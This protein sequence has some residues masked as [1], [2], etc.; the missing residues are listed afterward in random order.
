MKSTLISFLFILSCFFTLGQNT[1][2]HLKMDY[3][4]SWDG[5]SSLLKVD[6]FYSP[7][8]KDTTSF[9]YGWPEVGNQI[10]IFSV[11]KNIQT[12]KGDSVSIDSANRKIIV[13]HKTSGQK[14]LHY[15]INGALISAAKHNNANEQFRPQLVPGC[16]YS[17]SFN[18][19]MLVDTNVYKTL[20]YTWDKWP[21]GIGYFSS[22]D[23]ES[24]PGT[25]V[26]IKTDQ[27]RKI[28]MAMDKKLIVKT[29]KVG[30]VPYY[31][32][33]SGRDSLNDMQAALKPFFSIF[34]PA[35]TDFW[36]DYKDKDYFISMLPFLNEAPDNY[37]GI[38][39]IDGFSMRYTGPYDLAKTEVIAHETT[40]KWIGNKLP[41]KQKGMEYMWFEEGFN[42]YI[43]TYILAET[44]M[45][46]K[47]EFIHYINN[48]NITPHYKSP[49]RT[50]PADSIAKYFWTNHYY[51][52]LPYERGFIYAFYLDNQIRLASKGKKTIRDFMLALLKN[53]SESKAVDFTIDDFI[54]TAALFLP[55]AQVVAEVNKYMQN[56]DLLDFHSLKLIHDF[57]IHYDN[58]IPILTM[59]EKTD[60]QQLLSWK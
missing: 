18:V 48:N 55:K 13:W 35:V 45:I 2:T 52:K 26:T 10:N 20:S 3:H 19:F 30:D 29:Y 51:E 8:S 25:V 4:F 59:S 44:K 37:T 47:K 22:A 43:D 38:G 9:T 40:H 17:L 46:T 57:H 5:N 60:L 49:V 32:I 41:I 54:E 14:K 34:F 16:F 24:K 12:E 7:D 56:G 1:A 11:V 33:T 42:D 53:R 15:E 58:G 28:Y 39:L 50:A 36:Q 27:I 21:A 6:L 23:P 31:A